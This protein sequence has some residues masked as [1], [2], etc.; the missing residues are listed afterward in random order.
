MQLS[1]TC[2]NDTYGTILDLKQDLHLDFQAAFFPSL[3][4]KGSLRSKQPLDRALGKKTYKEHLNGIITTATKLRDQD[5]DQAEQST[6]IPSKTITYLLSLIPAS[7]I[8]DKE[9]Y[10]QLSAHDPIQEMEKI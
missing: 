9:H 10:E 5:S 7:T 4:E 2:N 3:V 6:K 8:T 1:E